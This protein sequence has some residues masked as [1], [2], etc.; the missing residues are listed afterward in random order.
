M[1]EAFTHRIGSGCPTTSSSEISSDVLF[2]SQYGVTFK[3]R[4]KRYKDKFTVDLEDKEDRTKVRLF[5]R[6]HGPAEDKRYVNFIWPDEP[7]NRTFGECIWTPSF[8]D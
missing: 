1:R 6:K 2:G 4:F 5:L 3:C 8:G 7:L